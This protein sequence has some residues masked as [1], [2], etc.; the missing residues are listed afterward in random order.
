MRQRFISRIIK[1]DGCWEWAGYHRADGYITFSVGSKKLRAHRVAYELFV[2]PIPEGLEIDHICR[3]R[4]CV[5]PAHLRPVTHAENM[6]NMNYSDSYANG[7][8]RHADKDHDFTPYSWKQGRVC[9]ICRLARQRTRRGI[10]N[11]RVAV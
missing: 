10:T 6:K 9:Q 2:G 3:N 8:S 7:D 11:F 1:S 4:G 5:N